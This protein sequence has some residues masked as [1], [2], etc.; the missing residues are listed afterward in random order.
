MGRRAGD[1]GLGYCANSLELGCDCLGAIR[2]FDAA[3]VD[4]QGTAP[5]R[6]TCFTLKPLGRRYC[7]VSFLLH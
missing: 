1:Y 6:V 4:S 2:Y 5:E 7:Q 3:F